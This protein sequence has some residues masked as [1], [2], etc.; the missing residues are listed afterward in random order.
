[1]RNDITI[2]DG[3]QNLGGR[4]LGINEDTPA[5]RGLIVLVIYAAVRSIVGAA[6]KR[7]WFDELCTWI[8]A[9]ETWFWL[10]NRH[11]FGSVSSPAVSIEGLVS[12]APYP[13]LLVV[14]SDTQDY[15]RLVY[16]GPEEWSRRSF[17]IV[18]AKTSVSYVGSD[19]L[20]N[21]LLALQ[22]CAPLHVFQ[23]DVFASQNWRFLLYSSGGEITDWWPSRLVHDK[24]FLQVVAADGQRRV[25]P[26]DLD[27][28]TR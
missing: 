2:A 14:I 11:H 10:E 24:Y 7:F 16:Y 21:V 25:Y 22:T 17:A 15:L 23:F 18:D 8:V 3:P 5:L 9:Q 6:M 28:G 20:D 4:F 13:E 1:M 12:A 19:T 26:V 27:R